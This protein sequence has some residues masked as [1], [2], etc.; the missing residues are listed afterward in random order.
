MRP[1]CFVI[2]PFGRK[3]VGA[4]TVDFDAVHRELIAPAID[5]AGLQPLRADEERSGGIIHRQMFERLV[6]CKFAVADLSGANANVF[7]EIGVRHGT[8]PAATVLI[9][10]EGSPPP[11]D[12][13]PCRAMPYGMDSGGRLTRPDADRAMLTQA[14]IAARDTRQDSPLHTLLQGF[15]EIDHSKT[16]TFREQVEYSERRKTELREARSA[17]D[18][19]GRLAALD[20][21]RDDLGPLDTL[22][23]GVLVDLLLSYR[24]IDAHARM[25]ALT[26]A[27]P[28]YLADTTL[29]QEQRG[30][31]LNRLG[32]RDEARRVLEEIIRRRGPAPETN[33]L[34][35]RVYKDMWKE[36]RAANEGL[37]AAS[38]LDRAIRCYR[39]GFEADWRDAYP[40]INAVQLMFERNPAD[41]ELQELVPVVRY[42]VRR[43]LA[44]GRADYWD[45]ATMLEL[46][47]L[48]GDHRA[49]RKALG[50]ALAEDPAA[51]MRNTTADTLEMIATR[52]E[53]SADDA[54]AIHEMAAALRVTGG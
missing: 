41:P 27:M 2:M 24:D 12:L 39:D 13:G 54:A 51:W 43:K 29:V 32:R 18:A 14:L 3:P 22:E 19:A 50:D 48:A 10:A 25:I 26:T 21:V 37:K 45:H 49:A 38:L 20:A 46:N 6:L 35:G 17:P 52:A 5:Q 4:A 7:Y 33:G 9:F 8:R 36:V 53:S 30:F 1:V 16:D 42:A 44:S 31:A 40:G 47:V 11:F 15:P 28:R 34:L 23:A